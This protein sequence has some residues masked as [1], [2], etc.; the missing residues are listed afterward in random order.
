MTG[1]L[2]LI[3]GRSGAGKTVYAQRTAEAFDTRVIHMDDLY[4]GW[5]G[6]AYATDTLTRILAERAA[7]QT[8]TWQR[9]DWYAENWGEVD[10]LDPEQPL[11][12]EGCGSITP[13]TAALADRVIWLEAPEQ[14]RRARALERDSTDWWWQRWAEQEEIHIAQHRPHELATEVIHTF[15]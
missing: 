5:Q 13:T 10:T 14:V 6:L 8:P 12:V 2:T 3:D 4:P 9:W 1:F 7:G 15:D 11:L